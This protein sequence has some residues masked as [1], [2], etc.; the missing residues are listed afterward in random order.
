[1]TN[2]ARSGMRAL[3]AAFGVCAVVAA[4]FAACAVPQCRGEV[5]WA[6]SFTG[7]AFSTSS[8]VKAYNPINAD[9]YAAG[10][11]AATVRFYLASSTGPT[12]QYLFDSRV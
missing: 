3:R 1:M 9:L 2:D 5:L 11:F 7:V 12:Y 8:N 6:E 4:L 10:R